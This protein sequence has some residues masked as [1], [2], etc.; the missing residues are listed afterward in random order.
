[1]L[2]RSLHRGD[3]VLPRG[4]QE[5]PLHAVEAAQA[6]TRALPALNIRMKER[7]LPAIEIGIGIHCGPVVVGNMGSPRKL[8]YTA[9]GDVV[10]IASRVQALTRV[11]GCSIL[12][13][14]EAAAGA[15]L[16]TTAVF[17][18]D[19]EVKGSVAKVSVY[20]APE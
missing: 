4:H 3:V 13:T 19:F 12:L 2:F 7:G 18:G 14:R 16:Q 10:N 5:A 9:I 6:M 17:A 11:A 1:M 8:E 15:R 20:R